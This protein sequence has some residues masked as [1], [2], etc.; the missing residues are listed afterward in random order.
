[1]AKTSWIILGILLIPVILLI[2]GCGTIDESINQP[3]PKY[4]LALQSLNPEM[5]KEI[6]RGHSSFSTTDVKILCY[7]EIAVSLKDKSICNNILSIVP[8]DNLDDEDY[9]SSAHGCEEIVESCI[10]NDD[11]DFCRPIEEILTPIKKTSRNT[12][13]EIL[14]KVTPDCYWALNYSQ[15]EYER[16][17][18][19]IMGY[20]QY[21]IPVYFSQERKLAHQQNV[22]DAQIRCRNK[23]YYKDLSSAYTCLKGDLQGTKF[24][25]SQEKGWQKWNEDSAEW[26]DVEQ[27]DKFA[28]QKTGITEAEK[29][30]ADKQTEEL[31]KKIYG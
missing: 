24:I 1:M 29:K 30:A 10:V 31:L 25:W 4:L 18:F 2:A 12:C 28:C 19:E 15:E 16:C 20:D 6:E 27:T 11:N 5:C 22:F 14:N 23:E 13:A 26:I 21:N 9:A 8:E 3:S 7:T 17:E